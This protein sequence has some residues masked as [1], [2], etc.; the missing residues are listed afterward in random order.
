MF[1]RAP[2]RGGPEDNWT[3]RGSER[4]SARRRETETERDRGREGERQREEREKV[5]DR[6]ERKERQ[7]REEKREKRDHSNVIMCGLY[8]ELPLLQLMA[9]GQI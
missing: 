7:K 6:R 5:E 9:C 1:L 3:Q 2:A 4:A 8:C